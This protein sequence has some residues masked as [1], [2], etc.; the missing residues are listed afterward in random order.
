MATAQCSCSDLS[1]LDLKDFS[2]LFYIDGQKSAM[3]TTNLQQQT[4][5]S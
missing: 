1:K 3:Q 5:Q 4:Q 2:K